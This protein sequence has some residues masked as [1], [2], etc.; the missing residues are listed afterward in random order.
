VSHTGPIG[1]IAALIQ[2]YK[3]IGR[4]SVSTNRAPCDNSRLSG[5]DKRGPH[6]SYALGDKR[7]EVA[8]AE[9]PRCVFASLAENTV[10]E[11]CLKAGLAEVLKPFANPDGAAKAGGGGGGVQAGKERPGASLSRTFVT[12]R[13]FFIYVIRAASPPPP[14]RYQSLLIERELTRN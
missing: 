13:R 12:G 2:H 5:P 8:G 7:A 9:A 3:A 10:D 11:L 4:E 1:I 14:R 6:R